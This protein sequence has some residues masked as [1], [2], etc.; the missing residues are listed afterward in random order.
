[1]ASSRRGTV[2]YALLAVAWG[3]IAVW[4][5]AEHFRVQTAAR[6]QLMYRAKDIS[7]TLGIV[8]RAQHRFGIIYKERVESALADLVKPE[9]LSCI[10]L[11]NAAG[12]V[13]AAAGVSPEF[14]A[15]AVAG[16]VEHWGKHS[17]TLVN[18][19]DLGPANVGTNAAQNAE[20]ANPPLVV[21]REVL[22]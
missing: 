9:E 1:M 7:T 10:A 4:Q 15:R 18:L 13:V 19:V 17:V 12:D 5:T 20:A 21:P 14:Q 11:F 16:P 8:L 22:M 3:L 2:I 6:A